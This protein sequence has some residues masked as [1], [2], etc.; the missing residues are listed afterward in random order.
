MLLTTVIN[1]NK[2]NFS[3]FDLFDNSKKEKKINELNKTEYKHLSIYYSDSDIDLLSITKQTLDLAMNLNQELFN[4]I[5]TNPY[6][7]IIFESKNDI[8]TFSGLEHAIG[9]NSPELNT[10][11]ILPENKEALLKEVPP[12]IWNYQKNILHE[13]T[14]YFFSQRLIDLGLSEDTIPF[15][16]KEGISEYIG[17]NGVTVTN[18]DT[19]IVPLSKLSTSEQW[20]VYRT[21]PEYNVYLQSYLSVNLLIMEYGVNIINDILLETQKE[22]DFENGLFKATNLH[23]SD[24]EANMK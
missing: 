3:F 21:N 24:L 16:F 15:W 1:Q 10:I 11:G 2:I 8:E 12:I 19:P 18:L 20:N 5:Y 14:H 23:L 4:V 22:N 7:I 17:F 13:Y 6:D 9:F